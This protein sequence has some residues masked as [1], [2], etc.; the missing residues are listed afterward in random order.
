[1]QMTPFHRIGSNVRFSRTRAKKQ[2]LTSSERECP[3]RK[4]GENREEEC[5]MWLQVIKECGS[6]P[7]DFL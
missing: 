3:R 1:M 6:P 7:S 5:V 2:R 4:G